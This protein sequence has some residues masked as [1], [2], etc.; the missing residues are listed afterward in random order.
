MNEPA[1]GLPR[2]VAAA[3]LLILKF[4]IDVE[5]FTRVCSLNSGYCVN[6]KNTYLCASQLVLDS[7]VLELTDERQS[8]QEAS[9][10][11]S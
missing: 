3:K 5:A 6:N 10:G 1:S 8:P 2:P 7:G 4:E 11:G 9:A